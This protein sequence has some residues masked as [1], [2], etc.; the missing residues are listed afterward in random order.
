[1]ANK[2][3]CS[4]FVFGKDSKIHGWINEH[5]YLKIINNRVIITKYKDDKFEKEQ[6]FFSINDKAIDIIN[7]LNMKFG[8]NYKSI[9]LDCDDY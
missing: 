3:M 8:V 5:E 4:I 7:I 2:I 6:F 1:M 9:H